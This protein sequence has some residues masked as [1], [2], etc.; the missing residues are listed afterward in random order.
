MYDTNFYTLVVHSLS[1]K[2][3]KFHYI[4]CRIVKITL[5]LLMAIAVM[6]RYQNCL[7]IQ[8]SA[9]IINVNT[10]E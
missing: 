1:R 4:I 10:L 3:E 5:R 2:S 9:H 6:R 8:D 7:I